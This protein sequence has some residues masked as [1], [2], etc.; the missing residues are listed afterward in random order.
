MA[1]VLSRVPEGPHRCCF[2]RRPPA[3]CAG[4]GLR[5]RDACGDRA[6]PKRSRAGGGGRAVGAA[7]SSPAVWDA[8][9]SR[10]LEVPSRGH[11]PLTMVEGALGG[12][13]TR[14]PWCESPQTVPEG[15]VL[16]ADWASG[17]GR[18]EAAPAATAGCARPW[19]PQ[20]SDPASQV[21]LG[22]R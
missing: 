8:G 4:R 18:S 17:H 2:S 14:P 15:L 22:R 13:A 3:A 5:L 9:A 21:G 10:G 12:V 7:T 6:G 11:R 19:G 20:R 1:L 16:S